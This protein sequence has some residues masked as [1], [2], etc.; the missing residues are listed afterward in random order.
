MTPN[1]DVNCGSWLVA[2]ASSRRNDLQMARPQLP[3]K[4]K[5]V[6]THDDR[7]IEGVRERGY[8]YSLTFYLLQKQQRVFNNTLKNT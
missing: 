4:E 8:Y 7:F 1:P 2:A 6:Q 5:H 3:V